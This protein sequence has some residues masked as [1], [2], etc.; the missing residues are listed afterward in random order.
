MKTL[1]CTVLLTFFVAV[2]MSPVAEQ[3]VSA[4]APTGPQGQPPPPKG[5]APQTPPA[6]A[7]QQQAP[8]AGVS[9]AVEV[10]VVTLDVIATT[11]HGDILTGLKKEN[12]R[13]IDD[14]VTQTITNFGPTEAPITIV[15]L[16]EFSSRGLY[17]WFAYQAKYWADAFLPNLQQK[18]WVALRTFDMQVHDEV[19]FTQNKDEVRNAIYHLYFPGFSESNV[20]D[21][22][23]KTIDDMK[24]VK[25]KKS[26]LL[27]ATGVDTFSK[28]TLDQTMKQLRQS[29]VT[30]FCVGLDKPYI[31]FL[32]SHGSLG[33]HM[34]YLQG[35]N[36]MRTIANLTGGYAWFPQ[37][38]GELPGI[39]H[40][41][42]AFLRHQYSLSYTPTSGGKDSKFH[43][44]KVELVDANGG[45]LEIH[46][47]KGKKQK[48]VVYAREGYEPQKS[49]AG[50]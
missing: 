38:D 25:G 20:F 24:D 1:L 46:D 15:M 14:G 35:E 39:F 45:P 4:Q 16:M 18:D 13:V 22:V 40:D 36:Q 28:H 41:V 50:D 44:V 3:H 9:I 34:N 12:F 23:L 33:S 49:G 30:I 7:P 6:T 42:A 31:N 8:Q 47:Q 5:A 48:W 19:D 43:K 29:D 32:E 17:E 11:Q 26:I 2:I 10:P 37:F 27:L 21:A